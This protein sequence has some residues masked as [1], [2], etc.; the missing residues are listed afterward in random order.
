VPTTEAHIT[1]VEH[2]I[3][4][5]W[6]RI[7][8]DGDPSR[9]D[10]KIREKAE[11]AAEFK[12]SGTLAYIEYSENPRTVDGRT[13]RNARY[14]RAEPADSNGSSGGIEQV[15]ETPRGGSSEDPQRA[16]R[17]CLQTGAKVAIQTLPHLAPEQRTFENQKQIAYAWA[18][19]FMD[20]KQGDAHATPPST[21]AT[22]QQSARGVGWEPTGDPG[23]E[24]EPPPPTDD[25]IP[26]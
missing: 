9:M 23:R 20:T 17:I 13:Y 15:Q 14:E 4:T 24:Y 2:D 12:K 16:W 22:V 21:P 25:D 5:G 6:Y 1:K 11:E 7:S 18:L 19:F 8:T 3:G 26:F 10:T